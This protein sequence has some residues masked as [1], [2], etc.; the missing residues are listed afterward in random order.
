[1]E[2]IEIVA[3]QD[4]LTLRQRWGHA[5][6]ILVSLLMLLF[7]L[8]LRTQLANAAVLYESPQAGI[9]AFYPQNWLIDTS[10]EYVF[11][12]RDMSRSGFKTTFQVGV[13]PIGADA[14]ERNIA[15]RLTLDRLQTL[16]AYQVLSQQPYLLLDERPAQAVSYTFVSSDASPF[17][18][19]VPAV[20]RGLDILTISGGQAIVITYLADANVFEQEFSRFE[21]FLQRLQF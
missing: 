6:A 18:Q 15:D 8:N 4:R 5:F 2:V 10:G 12:V 13:E 21:Q 7:S 17:L 20:V 11:R 19:G 9:L 3:E 14:M 16:T 1:M